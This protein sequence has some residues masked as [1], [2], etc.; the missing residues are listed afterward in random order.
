MLYEFLETMKISKLLPVNLGMPKP[1][2]KA[3]DEWYLTVVE[4]FKVDIATTNHVHI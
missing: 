1:V 2:L 4:F 3:I